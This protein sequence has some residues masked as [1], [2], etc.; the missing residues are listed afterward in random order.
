MTSN[1]ELANHQDNPTASFAAQ[2]DRTPK[3]LTDRTIDAIT[4][5]YFN[6]E[7]I[8]PPRNGYRFGDNPY[9]DTGTDEAFIRASG[10]LE[11]LTVDTGLR[12]GDIYNGSWLRTISNSGSAYTMQTI[13][14]P[15]EEGFVSV[16]GIVKR[17]QPSEKVGY[18]GGRIK[19]PELCKP[20]EFSEYAQ[21][22]SPDQWDLIRYA[23]PSTLR[24]RIRH[25][26]RELYREFG[27]DWMTRSMTG[28]QV[29]PE[30]FELHPLVTTEISQ[31]ELG[32]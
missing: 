30:T 7:N 28:I 15:D 4:D 1:I 8:S 2:E 5:R 11:F 23:D 31:I 19:L 10:Q 26:I 9:R 25:R 20:A 21:V 6:P 32:L 13:D 17:V 14:E 3:D 12:P 27:K 16:K 29:Y 22:D 18:F 24:G